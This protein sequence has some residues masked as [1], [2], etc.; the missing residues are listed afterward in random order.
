MNG[1]HKQPDTPGVNCDKCIAAPN[2][3]KVTKVKAFD[4]K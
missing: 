1:S 3:Y 4:S 2:L